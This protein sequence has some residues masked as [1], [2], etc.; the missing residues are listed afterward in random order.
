[1][2]KLF[3][4]FGLLLLLTGFA[5]GQNYAVSEIPAELKEDAYAVIRSENTTV[6]IY[7]LNK[8]IHTKELVITVFDKSGDQAA[9]PYEIYNPSAK[10]THLEVVFYD[11]KGKEIKKF[12]SKD[13]SDQSFI[14][15]GQMYTDER[16]KYLDYTP[17][18][19][20]YTIR[21][22]SVI[23]HSNTYIGKWFP[24]KEYN[25]AIE[26]STFT[27][28]NLM[29]LQILSKE[30][31]LAPYGVT[32]QNSTQAVVHYEIKNRAAFEK[33]E[34]TPYIGH[35]FPNVEFSPVEFIRDGVKGSFQDWNGM[36]KWYQG[37]LADT[38]DFSNSQKAYFQ[39]LVKD[40]ETDK[41]K[42]RILYE[43]L[44]N[45]TRYIGV[46]L[47][48]GGLK[49]FP[50]SYVESKSYGD[51]KA[52]T[53][54]MQSMLDAVNIPSYYTVVYAGRR[55]DF[56]PD[57]ASIAQGNH[58]ILY[59]PLE[60]EEIWLETTSQKSAFNYLGSFTENRNALLVTPQGGKIIRTQN[61]PTEKNRQTTNGSLE[62]QT[63]GK[64]TG[65][66]SIHYSGLQYDWIYGIGY[67][68]SKEQKKN[69]VE[70][71]GNLPNLNILNYR[72]D[73]DRQNANFETS[74][75]VESLE[76]AKIYGNNIVFNLLPVGISTTNLKKD[77]Q[78]MHP[79]EILHG[80]VDEVEFE[81]KYPANYQ[82]SENFQPIFYESEFG[83]YQLNVALGENHTLKV[84]RKLLVKDGEYPKEK[85]N[86]YVEFR[87]KISS[88]D[89]SKILLEKS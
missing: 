54:Y 19:Y 79:L 3:S 55:V 48:I 68:N 84:K 75:H 31:N 32:S 71:L 40:A 13:F 5:L 18:Q 83:N 8:V 62:V 72:F 26:N 41:E 81:I 34:L 59:V 17:T 37:L 87:R 63:N 86:D 78:R 53:N 1:M 43:H 2:K 30:M 4:F 66:L 77:D 39:N 45:K 64:L 46:Q 42:V 61:F 21:F 28:N 6:D 23:N 15:G 52:L 60:E 35:L 10:I 33:E 12:K 9:I 56:H 27:I 20:P 38:N 73:N 80:Y 14:T 57:F 69:L 65:N 85:F 51:C 82:V 89:N 47:G 16:V 24:F 88:F 36:G 11:G 74:M 44:Q 67:L 50:A 29:N 70:I 58:V 49:P 7:S 22:K 76:F 25:V